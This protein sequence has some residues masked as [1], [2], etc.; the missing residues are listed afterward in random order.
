MYKKLITITLLFLTSDIQSIKKRKKN[1][2]QTCHNKSKKMSMHR[3]ARKGD[4]TTIQNLL[5]NYRYIDSENKYGETPLF[6]AI[7]YNQKDAAALFLEKGAN[8]NT[9]NNKGDTPLLCA[10]KK[11]S[12]ECTILL[13]EKGADTNIGDNNLENRLV[14]FYGAT[15]DDEKI[16][17]NYKFIAPVH[18]YLLHRKLIPLYEQ[19]QNEEKV[20]HQ[21]LLPLSDSYL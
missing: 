1:N 6:V 17:E 19:Q 21:T 16:E 10:M 9:Y 20:L 12:P 2:V 4:T 11:K 3:A 15:P 7:R 18:S 13:L 14:E 5:P 8:P